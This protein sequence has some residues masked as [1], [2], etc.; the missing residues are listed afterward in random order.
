M[1]GAAFYTLDVLSAF[2]KSPELFRDKVPHLL[3]D[4][5]RGLIRHP[6]CCASVEQQVGELVNNLAGIQ[7]AMDQNDL[8]A[9]QFYE[10]WFMS[11]G[12]IA[13]RSVC[14]TLLA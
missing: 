1:I 2:S 14:N 3:V 11:Q 8:S 5:L 12:I 9:I 10:E 4:D 13:V 7:T 6:S